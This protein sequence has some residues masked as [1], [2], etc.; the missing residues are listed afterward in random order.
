MF[1][2]ISEML[3]CRAHFFI[4]SR[5]QSP[6]K[7]HFYV[8]WHNLYNRQH[9]FPKKQKPTLPISAQFVAL[10][11]SFV[12]FQIQ[13]SCAPLKKFLRTSLHVIVFVLLEIAKVIF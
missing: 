10:C 12:N 8:L 5:I 6:K 9:Q 7:G 3:K 2:R 1:N 13:M 4:T 11:S